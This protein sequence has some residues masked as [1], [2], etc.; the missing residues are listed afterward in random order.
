VTDTA[1]DVRDLESLGR[2]LDAAAQ[3]FD[4]RE[5]TLLEAIVALAHEALA[6]RAPDDV[7]GFGF[8]LPDRES[9]SPSLSEIVVTKTNDT[10]SPKLFQSAL[11]Q[12]GSLPIFAPRP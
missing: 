5:R 4:E 7:S 6:A 12:M 9:S 8:G 10:S 11:G 1:F 2:K 3:G